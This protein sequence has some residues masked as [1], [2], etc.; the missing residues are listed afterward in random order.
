MNASVP[1]PPTV[2]VTV[3]VPCLWALRTRLSTARWSASRSPLVHT[4]CSIVRV[5]REVREAHGLGL[6]RRGRVLAG[7]GEQVVEQRGQPLGAVRD[8]LDHGLVRPVLGQVRGVPAQRGERR[9]QLV[10]RVADEAVLGL[11]RPLERGEHRVERVRELAD[12]VGHRRFRQA[13]GGVAGAAD[14]PRSGRQAR[15]RTERAAREPGRERGGEQPGEQRAD[16]DQHPGAVH[17]ALDRREVGRDDHG[18]AGRLARA[19][20]AERRGVDPDRVGAE[21]FVPEP[22]LAVAQD[23]LV[24]RQHAPTER[25]RPRDD[26]PGAVHDLHEQPA[27][28]D[29]PDLRELPRHRGVEPRDVGRAPAQRVVELAAQVVGEQRRARR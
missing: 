8:V 15:E 1:S 7:Q 29:R 9:A 23:A 2:T 17:G 12:L 6:E 21:P 4:S 13:A 16:R 5:R 11:L 3:P 25:G 18:P 26:P 27:A 20:L 24:D 10:R 19:E 22:R 28:L 14:L